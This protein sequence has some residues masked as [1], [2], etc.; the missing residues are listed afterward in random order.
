[1]KVYISGQIS[2]LTWD[3]Y[4]DN[5]ARAEAFCVSNGV[6]VINPLKAIACDPE[7]CNPGVTTPHPAGGYHHH[8][9]CYM[10]YDIIQMLEE[11]DT[12]L[13]LPNYKKSVGA[14]VEKYIAEAVGFRVMYL[15]DNYQETYSE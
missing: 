1:M 4:S 6:P 12:I 8:W 7:D 15:K 13:M 5:F 11:C 3:E 9:R 14:G 10:K 2:G